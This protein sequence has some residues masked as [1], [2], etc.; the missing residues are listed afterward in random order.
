MTGHLT[1]TL[2]GLNGTL[3]GHA[4]PVVASLPG[5]FH[6]MPIFPN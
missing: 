1:G 6:Q 2:P 3:M 4:G 5:T